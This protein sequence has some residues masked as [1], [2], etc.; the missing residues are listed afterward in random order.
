MGG[1]VTLLI[2]EEHKDLRALVVSAPASKNSVFPSTVY[3]AKEITVP[4]LLMIERNDARHIHRGVDD[5]E[6]A[7]KK[8]KTPAKVIRY[9]RGGGH[10]LFFT[11][12]Y[13]W[14]DVIYFLKA[15]N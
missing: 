4:I 1:L 5:L 13:Y 15:H 3:Y 9:D 10:N 2:G 7:F 8:N 6:S 11:V 12:D 14:P